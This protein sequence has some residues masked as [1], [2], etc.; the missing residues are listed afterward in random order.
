MKW[1]IDKHNIL[2]KNHE[3]KRKNFKFL[4]VLASISSEGV[5]GIG[6][7]I[8]LFAG[9]IFA[10]RGII[11]IG[12]TVALLQ[13]MNYLAGPVVTPTAQKKYSRILI[14]ALNIKNPI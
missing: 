1:A 10:Y 11:Q 6:Q 5:S 13:L 9:G 7:V 14:Y 8:I 4:N 2:S 12:E 3:M